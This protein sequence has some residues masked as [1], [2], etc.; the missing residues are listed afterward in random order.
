MLTAQNSRYVPSKFSR[1]VTEDSHVQTNG[2]TLCLL[3]VQVMGL[4]MPPSKPQGTNRRQRRSHPLFPYG[5]GVELL[6]IL[7]IPY[8]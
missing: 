5:R 8:Q 3:T 6:Y 4:S 1:D 7:G 2:S